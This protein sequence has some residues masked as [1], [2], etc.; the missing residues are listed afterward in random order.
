MPSLLLLA[1]LAGPS[2]PLPLHAPIDSVI[3]NDNRRGAGTMRN[4]VFHLALEARNAAWRPDLTVDSAVTVRAFAEAGRTPRIPGPLIRVVEGTPMRISVRNA[5][6]DSTLVLHGLGSAGAPPIRI[7]PGAV[8]TI[9]FTAGAPGTY[10]YWGSTTD[11]PINERWGRDGQ[12]NGVL[13]VDPRG[14]PPDTTE[15]IFVLSM[16]DIFVDPSR[17]PTK[18]DIWEVAIN[19]RSW[20][21]TERVRHTVGDT[22]RWRWVNAGFR[23]HPMHLH[24]FHFQVTAKGTATDTIYPPERRRLAVTEFMPPGTTFSMSWLPT[25]AGSWLMHCHMIPHITPYPVRA[26]STRGNDI[27]DV[28][29]HPTS[30]MAGLVLGITTVDASGRSAA[31]PGAPTRRLRLVAQ[32]RRADKR[33]TARAFVLQEGAEPAR[34]SVV[35]PSSPLILTRGETVQIT[36]VNRQATHTS[37]HWHGMELESVYD[38][39]SG[40]SGADALR[41]PMLAEGD[42]FAVTFTPPRAGTYIYHTHMDEEDQLS[43]GMYGAMIVLEPGERWDPSR[44]VV[45]I[46][47]LAPDSGGYGLAVNGQ[48]R[49]RPREFSAGTTY[50]VRVINMHVV[51][52]FDVVLTT[53]GAPAAWRPIGKDGAELPAALKASRPARFRIAVGETYDFEWTPQAAGTSALS[54]DLAGESQHIVEEWIV[55]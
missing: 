26:D 40:W 34:D 44:D 7:P 14:T 25:R 41:A 30:A 48:L 4:G 46:V 20:P 53:G 2:Q 23:G 45:A 5:F 24:G 19:G 18:E 13:V 35:A 9:Q 33:R 49:P 1:L 12:L 52:P 8:Q 6:P 36:V 17:P 31:R 3:P 16:L 54:F 43:A 47:G 10:L 27:H 37:V 11:A 39:V 50:R 28:A 38:G 42:S 32:E 29:K 51:L 22:V 55:K 21:H 15:R